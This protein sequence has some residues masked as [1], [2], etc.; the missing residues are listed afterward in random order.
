MS[1]GRK[2]GALYKYEIIG[3]YAIF[4]MYTGTAIDFVL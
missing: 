1:W 4:L 3:H 2:E